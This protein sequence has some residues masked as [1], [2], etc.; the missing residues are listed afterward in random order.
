MNHLANHRVD[1]TA[2]GLEAPGQRLLPAVDHAGRSA[3]RSMVKS[4]SLDTSSRIPPCLGVSVVKSST[5][6]AQSHRGGEAEPCHTSLA[7]LGGASDRPSVD[8]V[9]LACHALYA[10][11]SVR[12]PNTSSSRKPTN[13][14][15]ISNVR[16]F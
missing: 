12:M 6:E 7:F 5:T 14:T 9:F 13:V 10:P 8:P 16:F 11:R 4:M 3:Q 2:S 1:P 15:M